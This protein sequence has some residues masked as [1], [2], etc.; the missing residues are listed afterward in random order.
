[1]QL[2][3]VS[4]ASYFIQPDVLP[5]PGKG[6]PPP[7]ISENSIGIPVGTLQNEAG[8]EIRAIF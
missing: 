1:M 2:D 3:A 5:E 7:N 4:T 8:H 6:D